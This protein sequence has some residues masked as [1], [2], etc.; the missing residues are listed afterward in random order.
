MNKQKHLS[1]CLKDGENNIS[2]IEEILQVAIKPKEKVTLLANEIK[3]NKKFV[4]KIIEYF[5]SASA[6]DQGH[7]IESLEYASQEKPEFIEPRLDFVI[8]HLKNKAPRVKWECAR[9]IANL[10]GK[11]PDKTEKA[12]PNLLQ[13]ATDK[14]TV[15]R[16]SVALALTEIAKQNLRTRKQ[17]LPIFEK[18]LKSEKNN[19]VKNIY[20]KTLKTIK[21][22]E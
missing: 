12:I 14:G 22:E 3:K 5:E 21:K 19:G 6:G 18:M 8:R 11:F 9:I 13:N 1:P 15:V 20:L 17:L 7:L 16:W 2:K 4:N 10:S